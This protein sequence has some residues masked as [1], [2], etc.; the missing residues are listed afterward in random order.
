MRRFVL[1]LLAASS[2]LPLLTVRAA[3]RPRYG[4]TLRVAV[5]AALISLDPA[6]PNQGDS[7][8]R[9]N[10]SSLIFDTLMILDDRGRPQPALASSWRAE[11]GSQRWQFQLRQGV[12]FS[13]GSPL[14]SDAVAASLRGANP[15]WRVFSTGETVVVERDSPS[16]N[17]PAE[18][19]LARNG[20]ARRDGGRPFGTGPFV[21][22]RWEPGKKLMLTARDDYW[23]GRPFLD[24]VDIDLGRA[25]REQMLSLDLGKL[26]L[27]E[28]APEQ[29]HRAAAESR[30]LESSTPMELM[31]LVFDRERQTP[32][33]GRLRAALALSIDRRSLNSVLLQGGGE[34]TGALL[35]N[36]M[37]GYAFLFSPDV[38][39]FKARQARGEIRQAVPWT[40]GYEPAD[41][42]MR[43]M[44]ERIVLNARDASVLV[45]PTGSGAADLRLVAVPLVSLDARVAL[46]ELAAG[47]GLPPSRGGANSAEDLFAAESMLLQSERVIPLLH[48][49][50][51]Y[52]VSPAVRNW[53]SGRDGSWRLQ[54]V[55]LG[56]EK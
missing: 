26:D 52:G 43:V 51:S 10:L 31:A 30:R 47:L 21:V 34:P 50:A 37:S 45:Q 22:T 3:T 32:E 9:R 27:V 2:L 36:W 46:A 16:P 33:E 49:R 41:P 7:L 55:W 39:L 11:P 29:A 38:D 23:A 8:A 24:A 15:G 48:L 28:V 25:L 53:T 19:A 4:G 6:D 12:S 35:P 40:L 56:S 18:L 20:I 13:D 54:D 1:A 17:L 44:A 42:V 5:R 14:T